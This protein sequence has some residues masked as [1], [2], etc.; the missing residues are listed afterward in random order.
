MPLPYWMTEQTS[1]F[2]GGMRSLKKEFD[3]AGKESTPKRFSAPAYYLHTAVCLL[4]MLGF[5]QLPPVEPLT[6]LGM[7]LIGIF[8]GVLYGW[9]CIEIVWPSLAGLLALMLVGGMK[10]MLL[11]NKSFGDPIVQ[12]MFFIFVFCATINHY[13][14]SKFISLWFITRKFVAGRPWVFTYTFL[15][16]IFIL[17]GLTSA[18][19]AAIIGWS[20]L[21]GVCEVCGFKKGDGYPTMMVFGIVFAAQVGMSLIPFKQ[22]ALTVFSAYE[23]MSG[24]GIDY[25]KYMLI[26]LLICA[27]CSLLFI[28]MGKYIFRPDMQKLMQLD[29]S[30]L[31]SDG[32]LALTRVQKTILGFLF[33]LVILLLVPN[34]LPRDFFL[35]RFLKSIGNTGIVILLVTVMAAIKVDGKPLLNFKIMVDSG[36]TWGIVLLL[37]FVQ[38]LS[39]AMAAP[40]S[41]ITPFL[42]QLLEPVFGGGTPLTFALFIG[43]AATLLTQVMNNGAVGVALMPIIY[44]YCQGAGASPELPL[45]MVVMG[46][47]FAFL[48]PAASASAALLH[49]NEWS[50]AKAIWKTAPAVIL[51]AFAVT[52]VITIIVGEAI[53]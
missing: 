20:I 8:L 39:G 12:M 33:L 9:I 30:K 27:C 3:M 45:I 14:L 36:V 16:S 47:H 25:A 23:T 26:A 1:A 50:D 49:G 4:I 43:L 24:V 19:P 22:A 53:F 34:F 51:M 38:P 10:P 7:N 6:P 37:A 15:G 44:S 21:Y 48:T 31:D 11:L 41:G 5:G 52:A 18:S 29:V 46:V 32:T 17:G 13:G 42:M 2:P 28:I 35:T 40:A